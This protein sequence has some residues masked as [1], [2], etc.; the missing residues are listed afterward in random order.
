MKSCY[1][2][3]LLFVISSVLLTESLFA[4]P[5]FARTYKMSCTTCHQPAPRLKA[6]GD[7]FAGNGF[8][9]SDKAAPRYFLNTGD[10]MLS[11][12]R[13]FPIAVRLDAYATYRTDKPQH[14]DFKTPYGVKLMSGG[15]LSKDVAYY[16][17]FYMNERG[18]VAGL[19][20]AYIMFNDVLGSELDIYVGQFQISDPLFK[21]EVRLTLEDYQIYKSR[22]AKSMTNLAYDRGIMLTYGFDSGTD[23]I[24]EIV[25]GNGL[26]EANAIR[27]YDNNDY[28]NYFGR[29]SQELGEYVRIGG[30][31]YYGEEVQE[32]GDVLE[33]ENRM[34]IY[35]PDVTISYND[36]LEINLQY[37]FREDKLNYALLGN[38]MIKTSGGFGEVLFLPEGADGSWYAAGLFNYI[39]SDDKMIDYKTMAVNVGYLLLRN[40]RIIGEIKYDFHGE[41]TQMSTGFMTAF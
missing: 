20:D 23:L 2:L 40:F 17:Y 11:L 12:I 26:E 6:Y 22:P 37:V 14:G 5:A 16:F 18:E 7:E 21:R 33:A 3:I 34:T 36:L 27:S 38:K 32:P 24:F 31:I 4:I 39:E 29:I 41:F 28:K 1:S 8:I 10:D 13:D 30:F 15:A 9:L 25:N 19:E 35:G